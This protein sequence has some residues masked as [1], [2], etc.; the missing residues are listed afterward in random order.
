MGTVQSN[1]RDF[2]KYS[3]GGISAAV[4]TPT[5]LG[6]TADRNSGKKSKNLLFIIV[7]DLK[8]VLGCYRNPLVRTPNLDRLA[9]KGVIFD[10]A[11]CQYPV[12]NPSRSSFLTGLR[13][14]TTRV[15]DNVIPWKTH[16]TNPVTLPKLFRDNGYFLPPNCST[17]RAIPAN[18]ATWP[19]ARSSA[20]TVRN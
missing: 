2:L 18:T 4:L 6:V 14:D 7:E 20:I 19:G 3:L 16:I 12:C 9:E 11:Y 1:R 17:M 15:L 10:R 5:L 8:N 13:P